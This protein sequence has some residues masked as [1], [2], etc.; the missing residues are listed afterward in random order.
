MWIL[1]IFSTQAPFGAYI[2]N[3]VCVLGI[4]YTY[5]YISNCIITDI[6]SDK[7]VNIYVN[8]YILA[9][10][11]SYLQILREKPFKC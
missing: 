9:Y 11:S 1:Y 10:I 7:N 6:Y 3:D 2:N 8:I 4:I 5:V